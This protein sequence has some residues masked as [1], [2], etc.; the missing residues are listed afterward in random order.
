MPIIDVTLEKR[1]ITYLWKLIN[2]KCKLYSNIEKLS[3]NNASTTIG[4]NMRYF[5]YEYK[6]QDNDWYESMAMIH[7]MISFSCREICNCK[8]T[9]GGYKS[10]FKHWGVFF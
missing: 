9:V 8:Y 5:M 10:M 4:G 2:S 7:T 3:L 1:C 6:F